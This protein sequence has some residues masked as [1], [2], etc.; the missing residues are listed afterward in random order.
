MPR[1]IPTSWSRGQTSLETDPM[2]LMLEGVLA[3]FS[4]QSRHA[5]LVASYKHRRLGRRHESPHPLV[6]LDRRR[7]Q[8]RSRDL[9]SHCAVTT[10]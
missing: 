5:L 9:Y 7:L 3:V 2:L 4:T 10:H 8:R 1:P 6:R